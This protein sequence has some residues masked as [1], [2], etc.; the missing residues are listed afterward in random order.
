MIDK[1]WLSLV[2]SV[3]T[4]L[5]IFNP[6]IVVWA[7][8]ADVE[9]M[10]LDEKQFTHPLFSWNTP[11]GVEKGAN[12]ELNSEEIDSNK[13]IMAILKTID[14]KNKSSLEKNR[15]KEAVSRLNP[16]VETGLEDMYGKIVSRFIEIIDLDSDGSYEIVAA[17]GTEKKG[18]F[19]W[20]TLTR[21]KDGR[22]RLCSIYAMGA[23]GVPE[24]LKD[25][26]TDGTF[27]LILTPRA[28]F[29]SLIAETPEQHV[30]EFINGIWINADSK[31][32]KYYNKGLPDGELSR[33]ENEVST[34]LQKNHEEELRRLRDREKIKT[35]P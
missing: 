10:W 25:L 34:K 11:A 4:I 24:D 16:R 28:D 23:C 19:K 2:A 3:A 1:R 17:S 27:E 12:E 9:V 33:R 15:V 26:N 30:Y 18:L 14:W 6:Q 32:P 5:L 29:Y 7:E 35:S 13:D 22:L 31:F 8:L 21:M 20:T